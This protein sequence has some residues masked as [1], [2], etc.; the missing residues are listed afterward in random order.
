MLFSAGCGSDAVFVVDL[1]TDFVPGLEFTEVT[2][3]ITRDSTERRANTTVALG[4]N[5]VRGLRM[6]EFSGVG[7]G[8]WL[9][10]LR[11]LDRGGAQIAS[12]RVITDLGADSRSVTV[13]VTRDCRGVRCGEGLTCVDGSC[14]DL[15]CSPE[16][17]DACPA[18]CA[19]D[20]EC[21]PAGASCVVGRC[22]DRVCFDVAD[23]GLCGGDTCDPDEGCLGSGLDGGVMD[24]GMPVT[25]L[26]GVIELSLGDR[27]T[28][29]TTSDGVRCW[30]ANDLGQ[31]GDGST[32][33]TDRPGPAA[34]A[35]TGLALGADHTCV[36]GG[37]VRCWGANEAGQLGVDA[38]AFSPTPVVAPT[39]N[40][41][42]L[43]AGRAHSCASET[44]TVVGPGFG[45]FP[46]WC[47][48]SN[49][50]GQLGD[51]STT[52]HAAPNTISV[53]WAVFS[54][55]A[56]DAH[57]CAIS[58]ESPS[59]ILFC[60]GDN[61]L[62]QLGDGSRVE[63]HA[64]TEVLIPTVATQVT[65]GAR[66]TCALHRG[67]AVSCWGDNA[68]GQVGGDGPDQPSP[69]VMPELTDAQGICAGGAHTCA[70]H[71][72]GIISCWGGNTE[73]QLGDGTDTDRAAPTDVLAI[74]NATAVACGR[75]HTCAL[76][77]D[78]TVKCWGDNTFGQL[79]DGSH[80]S[81]STPVD[82]LG[83]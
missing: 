50:H 26:S 29:A 81:T 58:Q 35:G 82:V 79:G 27:H 3:V 78:G 10:E 36:S 76:L 7:Q 6:A 65:A 30:G 4:A 66:H 52:S 75:A 57:T 71:E 72:T 31:L 21:D 45:D 18:G 22:V 42:L 83:P 28:C 61:R 33:S 64:P 73:G 62:G 67:G 2:T 38:P 24:A 16:N 80:M 23:D 11:L 68:S 77:D 44:G 54:A 39:D 12:G 20:S 69:R 15:R 53:M 34:F 51:G 74:T 9:V 19:A 8:T 5:A 41:G 49:D 59:A 43:A 60:W 17:R 32:T 13:V 14:Q 48:G 47:W 1:R 56:G 55:A 70:L 63:R 40:P 37:M 25:P 46:F